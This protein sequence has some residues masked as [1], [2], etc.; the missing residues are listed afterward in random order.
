MHSSEKAKGL[1][2]KKIL[3]RDHLRCIHPSKNSE[4]KKRRLHVHKA[5]L[6]DLAKNRQIYTFS[7]TVACDNEHENTVPFKQTSES[8]FPLK[9]PSFQSL[10]QF[11]RLSRQVASLDWID[12]IFSWL[13]DATL[14]Y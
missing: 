4:A 3:S 10:D 13:A 8:N 5:K 14:P 12:S 2:C 7:L 11:L 6:D 9:S 1:Y